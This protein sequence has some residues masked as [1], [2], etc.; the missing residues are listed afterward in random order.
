MNKTNIIVSIV[1]LFCFV[2]NATVSS[3]TNHL[4]RYTIVWNGGKDSTNLER[5]YAK[6]AKLPGFQ[7]APKSSIKTE[8]PYKLGKVRGVGYGNAEPRDT[9]LEI[10]A[11]IPSNLMYEDF[12]DETD[13]ITRFYIEEIPNG[14]AQMLVAFIGHGGNDLVVLLYSGQSKST[15]QNAVN[16]I[17]DE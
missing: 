4:H 7:K 2:G 14:E 17:K 6:V 8:I 12:R 16:L 13:Y 15:Y 3:A 11:T 1:A 10:L 5:A 9:V